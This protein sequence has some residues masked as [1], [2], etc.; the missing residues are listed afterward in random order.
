MVSIATLD[1]RPWRG[2]PYGEVHEAS[3]RGYWS[4]ITLAVSAAV[5][6]GS[7]GFVSPVLR[8]VLVPIVSMCQ[9]YRLFVSAFALGFGRLASV[10]FSVFG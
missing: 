10:S 8:S 3:E 7:G 5:F 4:V 1:R 6:R 9:W 2:P